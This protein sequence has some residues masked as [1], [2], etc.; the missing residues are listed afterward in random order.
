MPTT[1]KGVEMPFVCKTRGG[2]KLDVVLKKKVVVV[3]EIQ[4]II[5]TRDFRFHDSSHYIRL[6]GSIIL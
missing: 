3:L 1:A 5:K 4:E 6:N 2:K